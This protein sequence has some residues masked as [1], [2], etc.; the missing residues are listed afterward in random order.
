M[1]EPWGIFAIIDL[2]STDFV[3]IG[4][5]GPVGRWRVH[6]PARVN[7]VHDRLDYRRGDESLRTRGDRHLV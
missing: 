2:D 4:D 1:I 5:D 7:V 3:V 6:D